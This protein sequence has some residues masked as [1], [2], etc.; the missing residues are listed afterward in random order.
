MSP[1]RRCNPGSRSDARPTAHPTIRDV[2]AL[3]GVSV[4]TVSNVLNRP[5]AVGT[6]RR[7]RVVAAIHSLGF[8]PNEQARALRRGS[9]STLQED[10]S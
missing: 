4:G 1:Q 6:D 5:E 2:A 9:P 7:S 8:V 3:A 10:H